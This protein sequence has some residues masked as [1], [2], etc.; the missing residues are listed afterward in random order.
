MGHLPQ[1]CQISPGYGISIDWWI[2]FAIWPGFPDKRDVEDPTEC[3]LQTVFECQK[4]NI[5]K[6]ILQEGQRI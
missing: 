2:G 1:L 5:S 3:R 6:G 4:K